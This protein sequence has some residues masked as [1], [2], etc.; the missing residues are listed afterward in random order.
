MLARLDER[1]SSE[2]LGGNLLVAPLVNGRFTKFSLPP[3]QHSQLVVRQL[4][5]HA[6]AYTTRKL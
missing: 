6:G 3:L 1:V 5:P 4:H 2:A